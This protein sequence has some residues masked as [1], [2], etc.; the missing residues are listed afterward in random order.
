MYLVTIY[1]YISLC[2]L[3][4]NNNTSLTAKQGFSQKLK[5]YM[6]FE[7]ENYFKINGYK[8]EISYNESISF[9]A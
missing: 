8:I 1:M 9:F 6:N 3:M 2:V 5:I 7:A 4:K